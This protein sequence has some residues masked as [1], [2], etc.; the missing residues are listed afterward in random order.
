MPKVLIVD[1]ES[2]ARDTI[3]LLL[4]HHEDIEIVGECANG[5][6]AIEAI[7]TH[8]PDLVFLDIQMPECD[9]F[10]VLEG[11][12]AEAC[13]AVIFVTAYD[14]YAVRA[15]EFHALDYL[16]KPY[17]DDRFDKALERAL[18]HLKSKEV[19]QVN[20][21]IL[22][23]LESRQA[24]QAEANQYPER[25][26]VKSRGVLQFIP[27]TD[28]D[29]VEAAGDYVGLHVGNKTHLLRET[30]EN[31]LNQLDPAKFVRVH[32]SSII[33][34]DKVT[35]IHPHFNGAYIA[36]LSN[37]KRV[38]IS[39]RFWPQVEQRLRQKKHPF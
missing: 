21:R 15:F 30:M 24:A 7:R 37:N 25:F 19:S 14:Q 39:R 17:D 31:M 10:G 38:T 35:S 36:T 11:V 29:W 13:P 34:I 1:D 32:R 5:L 23:L 22:A 27:V 4:A 18:Q 2:L 6:E 12:G 26:A 33:A 28:I 16:L 3:R 9:G 20:E 8:K